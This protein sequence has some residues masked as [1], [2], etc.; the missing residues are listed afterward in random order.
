MT[1]T[2]NHENGAPLD[3]EASHASG[4]DI[5]QAQSRIP[6]SAAA[7]LRQRRGPPSVSSPV[8]RAI[9]RVGTLIH[10]AHALD[11]ERKKK[12]ELGTAVLDDEDDDDDEDEEGESDSDADQPEHGSA[13]NAG[14]HQGPHEPRSLPNDDGDDDG[15]AGDPAGALELEREETHDEQER[16]DLREAHAVVDRAM[17]PSS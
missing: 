5:E 14:S 4:A 17:E 6:M 3:H 13:D 9:N 1:G 7:S 15:A 12:P 16:N 2:E 11:F 8:A 10:S